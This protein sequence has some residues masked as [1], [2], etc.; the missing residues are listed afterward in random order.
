M[1][2]VVSDRKVFENMTRSFWFTSH[3]R[4][5]NPKL[6]F[7]ADLI[8]FE[9]SNGSFS[10]FSLEVVERTTLSASSATEKRSL[11]RYIR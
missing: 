2:S 6:Y 5:S 11:F 10:H 9:F 1:Y 3:V 4:E 8:F 7:Y